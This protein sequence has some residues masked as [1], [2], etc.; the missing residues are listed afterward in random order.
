MRHSNEEGRK[1]FRFILLYWP[2]FEHFAELRKN[3]FLKICSFHYGPSYFKIYH[4]SFFGPTTTIFKYNVCVCV[5]VC[6]RVHVI[7]VYCFNA[8]VF[9]NKQ[10]LIMFWLCDLWEIIKFWYLCFRKLTFYLKKEKILSS[11]KVVIIIIMMPC[12][13]HRSLWPSPATHLHRPSLLVGLQGYILYQLLYINSSRLSCPCSSMW[14]CLQEYVGYEFVPTSPAVSRMP[15]LSNL[16]S[17]C[18][19]GKWPYSCCF[20]ECCLQD[21]LQLI[22][23]LCNCRQSFSPDV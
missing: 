7:F 20:V 6:A 15:G 2:V 13:Q 19:G 14:R 10:Y 11:K 9:G 18:D 3:V 23:F 21:L 1:H 16:S 4:C 17:F 22:T 12:H 8:I 5:C